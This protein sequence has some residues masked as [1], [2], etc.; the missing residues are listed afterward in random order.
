MEDF[1]DPRDVGASMRPYIGIGP[2]LPRW[3]GGWP[4]WAGSLWGWD[5]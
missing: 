2:V 4:R 1:Q 5:L 3:G